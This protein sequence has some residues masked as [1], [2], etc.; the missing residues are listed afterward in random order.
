M[1]DPLLHYSV[2]GQGR[3]VIFLH[4]FME[5]VSMWEFLDINDIQ[6]ILIDLPGH[7]KSLLN[8]PGEIPSIRFMAEKVMEITALLELN[9][10]D[11]VG[12]SMG[13]YVAMLL[14]ELDPCCAKVVLLHSNFW[15]DSDQKKRDRIRMADLAFKAKELLIKEAIPGLF[16]RTDSKDSGVQNLI[17]EALNM[18]SEAIA[19]ASLAMRSRS[20]KTEL[21][22]KYPDD[23]HIIQGEHDPLIASDVMT[24]ALKAFKVSYHQ[25]PNAG[26][27]GHIEDPRS[28]NKLLQEILA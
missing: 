13:G 9:S 26:H 3:P 28:V 19:Y 4:G 8:D 16:Y 20:D 10:Y 23:I 2:Q 24:Q 21:L 15:E 17:A 22:T 25:L 1:P 7:G 12:H 18:S 5:S 6:A 11:V 27:M 14:K